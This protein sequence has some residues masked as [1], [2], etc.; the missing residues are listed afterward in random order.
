MPEYEEKLNAEIE[1]KVAAM[2]RDDYV[3]P[4]RLNRRDYIIIVSVC[5]VCLAFLILGINI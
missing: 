4:K 1:R 3:F 5:L 2:E